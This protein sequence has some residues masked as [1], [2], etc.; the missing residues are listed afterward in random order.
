M[1]PPR[2]QVNESG[3]YGLIWTTD[4]REEVLMLL[5]QALRSRVFVVGFVAFSLADL[6]SDYYFMSVAAIDVILSTVFLFLSA[7]VLSAA[8]PLR[9]FL[10]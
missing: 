3:R 4:Q 5:L 9:P 7:F 8:I 10:V 2:D 6:L 1:N